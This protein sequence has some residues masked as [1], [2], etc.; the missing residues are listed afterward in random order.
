MVVI[1]TRLSACGVCYTGAKFGIV[2]E[3]VFVCIYSAGTVRY[4]FQ[5]GVSVNGII[6]D[7]RFNAVRSHN[8]R[9]IPVVVEIHDVFVFILEFVSVLIGKILQGVSET[10][11]IFS[12]TAFVIIEPVFCTVG[13][14]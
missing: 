2:A 4:C 12:D 9:K 7:N 14:V 11:L 5:A 8:F 1:E 10:V 3:F 13:I 6:S